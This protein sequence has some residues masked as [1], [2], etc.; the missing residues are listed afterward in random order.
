MTTTKALLTRLP[1][2]L[3]PAFDWV[4]SA[5]DVKELSAMDEAQ[6][7]VYADECAEYA[8]LDASPNPVTSDDVFAVWLEL[9]RAPSAPSD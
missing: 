7:R 3:H 9:R 2:R 4:A 5:G 6:A 8:L 1:E